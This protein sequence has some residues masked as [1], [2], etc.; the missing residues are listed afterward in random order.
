MHQHFKGNVRHREDSFHLTELLYHDV[1]DII[2]GHLG[3]SFQNPLACRRGK[4]NC[5]KVRNQVLQFHSPKQRNVIFRLPNQRIRWF[6]HAEKILTDQKCWMFFESQ[7]S[8]DPIGADD[9]DLRRTAM[10]NPHY[11]TFYDRC[12]KMIQFT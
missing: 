8:S 9:F 2:T 1:A 4:S 12:L 5:K 10:V 11:A 3:L 7:G 6:T